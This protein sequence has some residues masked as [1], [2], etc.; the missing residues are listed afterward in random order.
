ME[1]VVTGLYTEFLLRDFAGK[2][3]P[4]L[5]FA[6]SVLCLFYTPKDIMS[7]ISQILAIIFCLAWTFPLGMQNLAESIHLWNIHLWQYFPDA[8]IGA[9]ILVPASENRSETF[10]QDQI[11]IVEFQRMACPDEKNQYERF[12]VIKEACG[13]LLFIF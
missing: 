7:C 1:A 11:R 5:F 10:I 9:Q 13:N 4:G 2:V 3:V 6:F 12:V 8:D